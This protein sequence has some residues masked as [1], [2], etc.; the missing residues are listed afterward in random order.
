MT[1][2]QAIDKAVETQ[3]NRWPESTIDRVEAYEH[4]TMPG[5]MVDIFTLES[6]QAYHH[7]V[8]NLNSGVRTL[9]P[10]DFNGGE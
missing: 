8:T 9:T 6:N 7:V 5:Y 10:E 2:G 3:M 1:I 4:P